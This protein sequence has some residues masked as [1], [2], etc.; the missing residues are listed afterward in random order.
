[1]FSVEAHVCMRTSSLRW[2]VAF[3][4]RCKMHIAT[5]IQAASTGACGQE[6]KCRRVL[7]ESVC[8][9][10]RACS[11]KSTTAYNMVKT[12][13]WTRATTTP[14]SELHTRSRC[15]RG[16]VQAR[17]ASFFAIQAGAA[18]GLR[19]FFLALRRG[20]MQAQ[21]PTLRRDLVSASRCRC[22]LL[23]A[24]LSALGRTV[25]VLRCMGQIPNAAQE[26]I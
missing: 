13:T 3:L 10:L 4:S 25:S 24:H 18:G 14:R 23:R 9:V 5:S 22:C 17:C 8:A 16:A 7:H 20:H 26:Q 15:H 6:H 2:A 21:L 19:A 1:M 11:C 12:W